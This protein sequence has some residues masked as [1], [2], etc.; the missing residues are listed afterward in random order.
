MPAVSAPGGSLLQNCATRCG[1][2]RAGGRLYYGEWRDTAGAAAFFQGALREA[3]PAAERAAGNAAHPGIERYH[4]R[5][6]GCIAAWVSRHIQ[7]TPCRGLPDQRDRPIARIGCLRN[8][9]RH[10]WSPSARA[11]RPARIGAGYP[12]R[13]PHISAAQ[14]DAGL[15]RASPQQARDQAH[16]LCRQEATA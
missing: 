12:L 10:R 7:R 8:G 6:A 5:L 9:D 3:R 16:W 13:C 14:D 4:H 15:A 1:R 11:C 2:A